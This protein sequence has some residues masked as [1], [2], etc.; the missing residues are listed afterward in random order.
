MELALAQFFVH[1]VL[2]LLQAIIAEGVA[3]TKH[4][5]AIPA[6]W[7]EPAFSCVARVVVV[8]QK[9]KRQILS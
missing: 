8:L 7:P 4:L 6:H 3:E 5:F 2:D 9:Y 1:G